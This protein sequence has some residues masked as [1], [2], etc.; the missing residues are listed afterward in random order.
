[1][2]RLYDVLVVG[3]GL[4][5]ATFARQA[6]DAGRRVLVVDRR[7]HVAG[8]CHTEDVGGI[9]VHKYGPHCF[10]TAN[11]NIWE[12][13]NRFAEFIPYRHRVKANYEGR[14]YTL[15]ISLTTACEVWGVTTPAEAQ[16]KLAEVRTHFTAPVGRQ[17]PLEE[18]IC[19][20]IGRQL[21]E[22]FIEG[23]TTKQWGKH[24]SRLPA[25]LI[26]RL[27]VR[28]ESHNDNYY[29]D[30][31]RYQGVPAGGYTAMAR[32]MLEGIENP[33][34]VRLG[35]DFLEERACLESLAAQVVYT[36]PIDA[37]MGYRRGYLDYRSLRFEEERRAGNFQGIGLVNYTRADVP[38]TRITEHKWLGGPGASAPETVITREY[39]QEYNGDNEPFYPMPDAENRARANVYIADAQAQGYLLAGRLATYRYLDM[40]MAVGQALKAAR[41]FLSS[42]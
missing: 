17:L 26:A 30:H 22:M 13:V 6:A 25:S 11:R 14:L 39:P 2:K 42:P 28:F 37:L 36:G 8:N 7:A 29:H 20:Q 31:D 1:M 10:H 5:G 24:P 41:D 18:H 35:V 15:P 38:Y 32:R 9:L 27:P 19:N 3:A 21:Y 16:A 12:Y 4:S 40:D 23:Y 33:I 34:E